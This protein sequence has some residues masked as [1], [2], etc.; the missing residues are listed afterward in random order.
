VP[1]SSAGE[2]QTTWDIVMGITPVEQPYPNAEGGHLVIAGAPV[3]TQA[4][5][6]QRFKVTVPAQKGYS[7]EVYANP[8]MG[9]LGWAALPFAMSESGKVDRNIH[10]ADSESALSLYVEKPSVKG[11]YYVAFRVPGANTGNPGSEG[12]GGRGG[13]GGPMGPGGPRR[14]GPPG[15]PP[16]EADINDLLLPLSSIR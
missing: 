2:V 9:G 11:F 12:R 1:G 7:Y 5:S 4:G 14:S 6:R 3:R 16:D 10:T 8:T 13:P 15:P